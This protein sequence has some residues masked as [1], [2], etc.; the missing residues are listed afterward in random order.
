MNER[1]ILVTAIPDAEQ[2]WCPKCN[3]SSAWKVPV[4]F[5]D[6]DDPTRVVARSTHTKCQDCGWNPVDEEAP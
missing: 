5:S 4:V 1:Y 3:K 2:V 6:Y